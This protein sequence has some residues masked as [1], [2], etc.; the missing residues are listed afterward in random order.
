MHQQSNH[1]E[2]EAILKEKPVPPLYGMNSK[3]EAEQ[4]SKVLI[5]EFPLA[6]YTQ[7]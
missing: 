2:S 3:V 1:R 5:S 7:S 6:F 4:K